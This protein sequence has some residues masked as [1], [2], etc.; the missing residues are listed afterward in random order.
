M[1]ENVCSS[2]GEVK[3]EQMVANWALIKYFKMKVYLFSK[4]L[5]T[6]KINNVSQLKD[7]R[8]TKTWIL[9]IFI[10]LTFS[11]LSLGQTKWEVVVDTS[12]HYCTVYELNDKNKT[13]STY[14]VRDCIKLKF[15]DHDRI[16]IY[17]SSPGISNWHIVDH[18][19]K[20]LDIP[21]F[22]IEF[23]DVTEITWHPFPIISARNGVWNKRYVYE[24]AFLDNKNRNRKILMDSEFFMKLYEL[25]STFD[26]KIYDLKLTN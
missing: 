13:F 26:K 25:D 19:N 21:H 18:V 2:W 22:Q 3:N 24:V 9:N 16:M 15:F 10:I 6:V 12:R 11:D 4:P 5:L 8:F 17:W 20:K 23:N 1:S 7:F 14:G